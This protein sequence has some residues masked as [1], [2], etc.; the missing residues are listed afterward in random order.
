M[1]QD[2]ASNTE[3]STMISL[4]KMTNVVLEHWLALLPVWLLLTNI[5]IITPLLRVFGG[6]GNIAS[7]A[8][9]IILKGRLS[10]VGFL[11]VKV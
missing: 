5:H 11:Q 2:S 4:K 8:P 3:V 10:N 9:V 6:L 7:S 1:A